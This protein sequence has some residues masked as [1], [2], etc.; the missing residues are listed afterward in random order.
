MIK[1]IAE[2]GTSKVYRYREEESEMPVMLLLLLQRAQEW[3]GVEFMLKTTNG[4]E[5]ERFVGRPNELKN[6][7]Q[8]RTLPSLKGVRYSEAK[9]LPSFVVCGRLS[10]KAAAAA[11]GGGY[12]AKKQQALRKILNSFIRH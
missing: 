5:K 12:C 4:E 2:R 9:N 8:R 6:E 11:A 3:S 1:N 7:V 10:A